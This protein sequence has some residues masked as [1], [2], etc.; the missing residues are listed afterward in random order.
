M[1]VDDSISINIHM[2]Q[3][4]Q[5][6]IEKER[7]RLLSFIRA[8]VNNVEDAEDIL[9]D[10]LYQFV[11]GYGTIRS[12]EKA[13]SW[14]FRVARNKIID[15][16]RKRSV[17]SDNV[18]LDQVGYDNEDGSLMLKDILP[19]IEDTPEEIHFREVIWEAINVALNELPA[20]QREV[21]V[22]HEF[23]DQSFKEI[24]A[25]LDT[26]VNTLIS[27]KRYAILALRKKLE[28]LYKEL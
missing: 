1:S 6:T 4:Q 10:V 12:I 22:L 16:Y 21:F 25:K 15:S 7:G 18:K 19:D 2:V 5:E 8:R 14:L 9:Q 17:R 24:S 28:N 13:T 27:R 23:E 3:S 11:D 26:P 20:E